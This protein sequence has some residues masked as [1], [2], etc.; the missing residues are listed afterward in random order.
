MRILIANTGM[1]PVPRYGGT[2]RVVWCLGK[3]LAKRG[4]EVTFLVNQGSTCDFARV[5]PL[6]V[7][8][9]LAEQIPEDVDLVHFHFRLRGGEAIPKPYLATLHGNVGDEASL[10]R[11]TVF[12]SR[13]HARRH[14]SGC[15]VH[16]GLDWEEYDRPDLDRPRSYFHFL[17]NAA[18]RVKNVQ[19]AIDV[20]RRVPGARLRVL[21]GRRFNFKMGLRF[22]ISPRIRFHGMVG[23]REKA[24]L[25]NGSQGLVFP[26][27]WPEPFGLAV[28]ESLYYGCPVFGTPHGSLPELVTKEVGFLSTRA[29]ELAEALARDA[30]SFSRKACHETARDRF[31]SKIMAGA[32]LEK[33]AQVLAGENLNA[34]APRLV[35]KP[36][37]RFLEW[38]A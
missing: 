14:G 30:A 27:R 2:E 35:E 37:G 16:N 18:W 29:D 28:I 17:G 6:D 1:I 5:I 26:V 36:A 38:Q 19:G 8:K 21:G 12:V 4:H 3:E 20:V 23:G 25:L 24:E 11:N 34:T 9:G 22:T 33:Y 15:F 31:N 32:Y 13:D 7:R 10:D